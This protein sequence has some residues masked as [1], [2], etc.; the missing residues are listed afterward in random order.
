LTLWRGIGS[1]L[2]L[3]PERRSVADCVAVTVVIDV[4]GLSLV[5]CLGAVA[6]GGG[7]GMFDGVS[8]A[9]DFRAD[10]LRAVRV[11]AGLA[12]QMLVPL[13]VFSVVP[14]D[15]LIEARQRDL[16]AALAERGV[17]ASLEVVPDVSPGNRI[18]ELIRARP[19]HLPCMASHVRGPAA[20]ALLGS[21]ASR[22][23]AG[24]RRPVLLVGP[25]SRDRLAGRV[26]C[27]LA[28]VDGSS[29]GELML[30]VAVGLARQLGAGLQLVQVLS[31]GLGPRAGHALLELAERLR[32]D[33]GLDVEA[34]QLLG[35][36]AGPALVAALEADEQVLPC[37][38][39][40]G[41][42]GF[43]RVMLGSVARYVARHAPMPVLLQTMPVPD[44]DTGLPP[45]VYA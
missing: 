21:V 28:C 19:G 17:D 5:G 18:A 33:S 11:A 25:R 3:L 41:R 26:R 37:M 32:V 43:E 15:D 30:P 39:S 2:G 45:G 1:W 36:D 29:H 40:H 24:S 31:P 13:T 8:L 23:I 6:W 38:A 27:V 35:S 12:R 10:A 7:R 14:D 44:V 42:T 22:A 4:S 20:E 9:T 16:L 34:R